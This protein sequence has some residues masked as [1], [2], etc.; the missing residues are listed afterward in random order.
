MTEAPPP[1]PDFRTLFESAPG[2]YLV[3]AP[4]LRILA[5]SD[6]Y[7]QATM[8]ARSA[9]VGR[10]I[11]EVFPDNPDDPTAT[12]VANLRAS[13]ERALQ[14]RAPDAMAVQKYDIRRPESDGGRFEIRH[15]SPVNSPVL[16]AAGE[17]RYI[18]HRVE[19]VT[20]FVRLRAQH[21]E[22]ERAT[23]ELRTRAGAMEVEIFLRAQELQEA[24]QRLRSLHD[25]LEQRVQVRTAE[26]KRANEELRQEI[27]QHQRTADAL[28][29]SEVQFRHAQKMEA[30]GRL[31]G[32]V[33]HDFNNLLSVI[34]SYS[35]LLLRD[36]KPSDP[37]FEDLAAIRKAGE[38]A[39]GLTRHL[40][41][42][43][44]QQVLAPRLLDLN[45]VVQGSQGMLARLLGEDVEL[46][47]I[48]ERPLAKVR[49]DEGQMDQ[50]L[51]NLVVNARD[52]MPNGGKLTIE[53]QN[54]VLDEG[55]RAAH[56][57]VK[58]G[59]HVLL[60]VSDTGVGMDADTQSRIFEPFFTTKEVGKG[61]GLGLSTVFGIDKQS[62]G[63]IWVYSEPGA[64][65]TFKIYLPK[66]SDTAQTE[67]APP[68]TMTLEG[69][70][71][72]LLVEDQEE[73]RKVARHILE[74]YGYR[75]FEARNAD[76]ALRFC[77]RPS[78]S[79]HLLLT[80]VVMPEIGGTQL[81]ARLRAL[82]PELR[83]LYMSGYTEN[84]IVH[85]GILE[86]GVAYLQKPLLPEAL[87]R[88]VREVLDSELGVNENPT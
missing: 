73:V 23:E 42:F 76:E 87:A 63:N 65:T 51:M 45:Q 74:R 30:V 43:S 50:V 15:W 86:P 32:S 21:H 9:I 70:E 75:V 26:L 31:A 85:H 34:L 62:G 41:A 1:T 27:E 77:E 12:G 57:D 58:P 53:T 37:R 72:I 35:V 84:A 48:C 59:P 44:R 7:L 33:A 64:G 56:L 60:A 22:R 25:D 46:I 13:L 20:E 47:T 55:Y 4:D 49:V 24:N 68:Q 40:L 3:L 6:A 14:S 66:A 88:R 71:S 82:R 16:D 78:L 2:L 52:A 61:T 19:D 11:F 79:I 29:E 81:A 17:V 10:H 5:A 80:D 38:K 39:A 28:R 67:P 8:T 83:V 54:V 18:I 36:T 69:S